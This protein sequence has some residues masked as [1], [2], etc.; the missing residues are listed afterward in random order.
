MHSVDRD[1]ILFLCGQRATRGT[2]KV[3][4]MDR[5]DRARDVNISYIFMIFVV[6]S[7]AAICLTVFWKQ[8]EARTAHQRDLFAMDTFFTLTA[9]GPEAE[10]G[11]ESCVLRVRELEGL[12]SVTAE[13]SDVRKING[14]GFT[15]V[16]TDTYWLI[17]TAK[18]L[19]RETE[20]ALDITLYPV[21][22]EWGFTTGAYAIPKQEK[23]EE[24]LQRV[25]YSQIYLNEEAWTISV[26]AGSE[27]DLGAVAKG[28][29]GDCLMKILK[30]QGITSA[31]LDLG[32]NIQTLGTKPDG[33]PWRIAVK[34]P[35]DSSEMI[36]VLEVADKAVIT[37]GS[38]ERYFVG[39]DGRQYW[40]ILDPTDGYPADSGLVSVTI[41]G[42]N[43]TRCD[44]LS[45]AL[46]VMGK[47]KAV[48][49]W[50]Q[51][52]DFEMILVT[53]DGK[54]YF[55]QGLEDCFECGEQWSA[56]KITKD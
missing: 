38:Y 49:F 34:N 56:E 2:W 51:H 20:G 21:L 6:L 31:M 3:G 33:S 54:I 22:R 43:G 1:A 14:D 27:L 46:F 48:E 26:P 4:E 32:G 42:E 23:L 35:F 50:E 10:E 25:D 52:S 8:Q 11:L 36:G 5:K 16:S 9:Y 53:E 40:H 17:K 44:G 30:E 37:S 24:L 7:A 28:Y 12:L 39:E 47:E 29:T 41:V 15:S 19:C 13:G 18:E 45:T 55:S